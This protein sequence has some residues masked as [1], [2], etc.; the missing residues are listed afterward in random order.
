M[1]DTE[2]FHG[3]VNVTCR[4]DVAYVTLARPDKHNGLDWDMFC[5]LI[6]AARALRK[7][8]SLRAV[9]LRGEGPSF[10]SGLDVPSFFSQPTKALRIFLKYGVRTTNIAQEAAWCWRRLS[11]P[12]IAVLHGRCYGGGLQIALAA[13]FRYATPDCELSV[14]EVKWGL[15]PDMTGTV[16]LRELLPMDVA[17]E[18]AM[19]GRVFDAAEAKALNLVSGVADNPLAA[20]ETLVAT[21]KTRSPDAIAGVKALF[22][23]TWNAPVADAFAVESRIQMKMFMSRNQR[24]AA[25]ANLAR[26]TP[27][28][29]ARKF[30]A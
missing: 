12:V 2:N 11:V 23:Q 29:V 22:D 20:A 27:K 30:D 10:C 14:M 8:R 16:T 25:R 15:V 18:L 26:Q 5:G 1:T 6:A 7:N 3:R 13:D 19:T 4:D 28:Y 17:K 9:I 24:I 21:I